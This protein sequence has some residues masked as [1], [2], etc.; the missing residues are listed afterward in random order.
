M[1][2]FAENF[3]DLVVCLLLESRES[4][5]LFFG[6]HVLVVDDLFSEQVGF[7]LNLTLLFPLGVSHLC[8]CVIDLLHLLHKLVALFVP[9]GPSTRLDHIGPLGNV[10]LSLVLPALQLNLLAPLEVALS[11]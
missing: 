11:A 6:S 4:I 5:H 3:V 8:L 7:F 10:L 1:A 9:L 2:I